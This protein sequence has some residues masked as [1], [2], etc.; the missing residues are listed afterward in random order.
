MV[1]VAFMYDT[2]ILSFVYPKCHIWFI[3]FCD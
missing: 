2:Q 3:I 1:G